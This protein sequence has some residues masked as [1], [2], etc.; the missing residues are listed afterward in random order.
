MT[1]NAP[2]HVYEAVARNRFHRWGYNETIGQEPG[3]EEN[4]VAKEAAS[5]NLRA[6]ADVV[7]R[8]ANG[9]AA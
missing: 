7:W 5:A 2:D 9:G 4:Y 3:A 8:L 6:D 1:D